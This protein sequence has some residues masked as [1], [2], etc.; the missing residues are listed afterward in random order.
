MPRC[1]ECGCE[2]DHIV[3]AETQTVE[4]CRHC[5]R[6]CDT[7]FE[8]GD[9][10][11]LLDVVL[12]R[13][14]AW[15]HV[16]CNAGSTVPQLL[17]PFVSCLLEAVVVRNL[18]VLKSLSNSEVASLLPHGNSLQLVPLA[19]SP[20]WE[21]M[22]YRYTIAPLFFYS[23]VE[24]AL[25]V[26]GSMWMGTH[27]RSN[28]EK[29]Q[30]VLLRWLQCGCFASCSKLVY[31]LFLVW[32]IPPTMLCLCDISYFVWLGCGFNAL[33]HKRSWL[34]SIMGVLLCVGVRALYRY[35]TKWTTTVM[36]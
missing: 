20:I 30:D 17:L 23:V 5:G 22:H 15:I 13:R 7:Y 10:Q 28:E 3:S 12:L 25:I 8:F 29:Y 26:V 34:Y 21:R 16:L 4:L 9:V 1:I 2:V 14:R 18:S 35:V 33:I 31:A 24:F 36:L 6:S 32:S 27:L 19:Q 11:K